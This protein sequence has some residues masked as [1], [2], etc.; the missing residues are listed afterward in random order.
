[1]AT[2]EELELA[3]GEPRPVP[4]QKQVTEDEWRGLLHLLDRIDRRVS[5]LSHWSVT[6]ISVAAGWFAAD[7]A[8][9]DG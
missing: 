5:R 8:K 1:M 7:L 9:S 3:F 4:R 6:A 2:D